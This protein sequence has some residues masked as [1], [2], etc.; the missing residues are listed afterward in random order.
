MNAPFRWNVR[1][2][3]CDGTGAAKWT[4]KRNQGRC[5]VCLGR[6]Q[7]TKTSRNGRFA[8]NAKARAD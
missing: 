1:C 8:G 7:V 5:F 6:G 3:S 2:Q 4:T